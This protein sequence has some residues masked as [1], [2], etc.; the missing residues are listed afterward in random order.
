MPPVPRAVPWT[1]LEEYDQVYQWLYSAESR[2][3]KLGIQH[4]TI[5]EIFFR[6]SI[7]YYCIAM[8]FDDP[9]SVFR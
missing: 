2:L 4:V 1:G 8:N 6:Q 5:S 3:R 9:I 7:Y